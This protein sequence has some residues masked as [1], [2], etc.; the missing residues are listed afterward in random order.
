MLRPSGQKASI[1]VP[2][3]RDLRIEHVTMKPVPMESFGGGDQ[4]HRSHPHRMFL[5]E[6]V[7]ENTLQH[8]AARHLMPC[9][10]HGIIVMD[11]ARHACDMTIHSDQICREGPGLWVIEGRHASVEVTSQATPRSNHCIE[12]IEHQFVTHSR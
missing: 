2:G 3:R 4:I 6:V 1:W 5:I 8:V 9:G 11:H 10:L 7:T 12:P